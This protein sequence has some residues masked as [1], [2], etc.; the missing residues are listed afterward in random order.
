MEISCLITHT[1]SM[2]CPRDYK[3]PN[4]SE[5]LRCYHHRQPQ[6]GH[7]PEFNFLRMSKFSRN[8]YR[9]ADKKFGFLPS[10]KVTWYDIIHFPLFLFLFPRFYKIVICLL[11]FVF[12]VKN[13]L[14][15]LTISF[16][17]LD[18]QIGTMIEDP[19]H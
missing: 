19:L 13:I 16:L 14:K 18:L 1:G 11:I 10:S 12:F 2:Y 8:N 9:D 7:P 6:L 17:L 5:S 15:Q 4:V 3:I